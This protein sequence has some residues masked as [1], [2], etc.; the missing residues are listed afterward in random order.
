LV[1]KVADDAF[2]LGGGVVRVSL[3]AVTFAEAEQ[4][5]GHYFPLL[6][7]LIDHGLIRFYGGVQVLIRLLLIQPMLQRL[8]QSIN[9]AR[10]NRFFEVA[11]EQ[12]DEELSQTFGLHVPFQASGVQST[13]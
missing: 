6:L 1:G 12:A 9:G 10:R 3:F 7:R 4:S 5:G 13:P 11:G 2:V 8:R